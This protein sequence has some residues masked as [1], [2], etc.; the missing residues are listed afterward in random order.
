MRQELGLAKQSP[1]SQTKQ[2]ES[3]HVKDKMAVE[4]LSPS[5]ETQTVAVTFVVTS[6]GE[7]GKAHNTLNGET[8]VALVITSPKRQ[9]RLED[10]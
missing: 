9:T 3:N 8:N 4:N 6:L 5:F 2:S 10:A 7:M 1:P